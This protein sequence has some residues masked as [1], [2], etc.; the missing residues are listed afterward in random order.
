MDTNIAQNRNKRK[1]ATLLL[2]AIIVVV[3]LIVITILLVNKPSGKK[4][5]QEPTKPYP[6]YSENITFENAHAKITL[7]GTLTLPAKE[8]NYPA[9]ILITGSGPQNRDGEGAGHK[10]FLV[11]SDYLTKKGIAVLR[12][13]DRGF[14]Q[15]TGDF[16]S[17]TSLDFSTD[18][19]SAVNYLKTRS[20]INKTKIG[21][22]GH[23]D[24]GMI[25]PM[26]AAKSRDVAFIVLLAGP[27]IHGSKLLVMRQEL[28]AKAMGL[29]DAEAQESIKWN[30]KTFDI[31]SRSKDPQTIKVDLT[32]YVKENPPNI[33]SRFIPPGMTRE[34]FVAAGID[35]LTSP[36]FSYFLNYDP[37]HTLAKVTC[38]VLALNGAKDAQVPSQE[39]LTAISVALKNGG[40]ENVTIKELP[41]LNHFFQEC[42]SCSL[43]EYATLDQTFSP[44]ALAEISNWVLKQ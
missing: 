7:S 32:N 22:V 3:S 4:R 35:E 28:M 12:Y 15:S 24:G 5:S 10:P 42:K 30:E 14:G 17:G 9:V 39:N 26:V 23:S 21:L 2:M 34:Q 20:E 19:E 33:P 37:A 13:D 1:K 18:V 29:S 44:V 38:P 31:V 41:N 40:N 36:W 27:G 6:Y 11:I 25:A 16:K 8:E 43:M